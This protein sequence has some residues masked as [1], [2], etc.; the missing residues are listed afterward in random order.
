MADNE[1]PSYS[2]DGRH[3]LYIS[4]RTGSNQLYIS[5]IDGEVERRI[6]FDNSSYFKPHWSPAFD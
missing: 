2:P 4:N 6:T 5:T 3:V 1:D